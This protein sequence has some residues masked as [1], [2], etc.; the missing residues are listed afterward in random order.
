MFRPKEDG[1]IFELGLNGT[2]HLAGRNP[3]GD[4]VVVEF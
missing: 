3:V 4:D 2:N 1:G